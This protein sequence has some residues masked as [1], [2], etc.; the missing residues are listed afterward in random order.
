MRAGPLP[1]LDEARC[2]GCGACVGVCPAG[3]LE[4]SG[5]LPWMPRPRDCVACAVCAAVCPAD[6]LHMRGA[7]GG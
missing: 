6:A 1:V 4:Q 7:E 3:C 2:V 5:P